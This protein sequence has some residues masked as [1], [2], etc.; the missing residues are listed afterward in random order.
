MTRHKRWNVAAWTAMGITFFLLGLLLWWSIQPLT[1][2]LKIP[3]NELAVVNPNNE[4]KAGEN[5]LLHYYVCKRGD[6]AANVTRYLKDSQIITLSDL[7]SKFPEGCNTYTV[8][9]MIP[10]NT[11]TDNYTF[12]AQITYKVSPIK[13]VTYEVHTKEFK[14]IGK[15]L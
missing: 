5:L 9:V 11:P 1:P 7:N 10:T 4:V 3:N 14:I 8:P 13:T 6:G 15:I 12:Y 2:I